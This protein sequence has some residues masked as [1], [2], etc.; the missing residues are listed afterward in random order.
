MTINKKPKFLATLLTDH[1]HA[2]TLTDQEDPLLPVILPLEL[3]EV[4]LLLDIRNV[5]SNDFY[6]D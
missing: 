6:S 5:H 2:L 4:I 3:R 1:M